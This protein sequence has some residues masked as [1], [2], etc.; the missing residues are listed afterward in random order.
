MSALAS[1]L[2]E[3]SGLDHSLFNIEMFYDPDADSV[4]IIEVN[5]RMSYQFADLYQ[6]VDGKNLYEVQ[7]EISMGTPVR[8]RRGAGRDRAAASFVIRRFTDARVLSVPSIGDIAALKKP[9]PGMVLHLLCR[10]GARLSDYDQDVGSFRYAI[11]NLSA[12]N[13]PE[14]RAR[15]RQL[16]ESLNF[17]FAT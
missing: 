9:Y 2:I 16:S 12:P 8:W 17:R 4:S 7:L 5:P 13:R 15:Y 3:G 1:R 11:V 6:R 14:L 10:P